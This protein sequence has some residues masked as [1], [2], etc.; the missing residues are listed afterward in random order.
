MITCGLAVFEATPVRRQAAEKYFTRMGLGHSFPGSSGGRASRWRGPAWH[1]AAT[2]PPGAEARKPG[3]VGYSYTVLE[4]ASADDALSIAAGSA[5]PIDL[6]L[7]DVVMPRMNG[8]ELAQQIS[9][10]RAGIKVR[11]CPGR[12]ACPER[13]A[14]RC[15]FP[16]APESDSVNLVTAPPAVRAEPAAALFCRQR[17]QHTGQA[18]PAPAHLRLRVHGSL[19]S[20]GGPLG[21]GSLAGGA[22]G[23]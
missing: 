1:S 8:P 23:G 4:A 12:F 9:R 7:T 6:M 22:A 15:A 13:C 16:S 17:M 2:A 5:E 11:L 18:P 20:K 14:T 10:L 3:P 19:F 21:A